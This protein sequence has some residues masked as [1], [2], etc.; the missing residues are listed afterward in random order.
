VLA[1][2]APR[3]RYTPGADDSG[4]LDSYESFLSRRSRFGHT[5][6]A[7]TAAQYLVG[8]GDRHLD[9]FLVEQH[10][11]CI[12]P[13]DFG[14]TFGLATTSL[15]V[16]E[17][18]PLRFTTQLQLLWG[19][20]DGRAM[21]RNVLCAGLRALRLEEASL[22]QILCVFGADPTLDW[23][24]NSVKRSSQRDNPVTTVQQH[25]NERIVSA[26]RRLRGAH[27]ASILLEHVWQNGLTRSMSTVAKTCLRELLYSAAV[28]GPVGHQ[29]DHRPHV[30]SER[31]EA[32]LLDATLPVEA[33]VDALLNMAT[34]PGVLAIS[35]VGW[36]PFW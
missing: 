17:L 10:S 27:P 15:P 11:G 9:N 7:A 1:T 34:H 19:P 16:P 3:D 32:L 20:H 5:L 2:A 25:S 29:P 6:G 23:V 35:W 21:F 4:N 8:L 24:K 30:P 12:V 31:E 22:K 18:M 13:I 26:V 33:Q 28:E 36:K 14:A